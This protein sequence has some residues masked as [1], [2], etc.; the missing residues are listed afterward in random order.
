MKAT[1]LRTRL[2]LGRAGV[3][4]GRHAGRRRAST[5]LA[6]GSA[7]IGAVLLTVMAVLAVF[8]P[9]LAP[10]DPSLPVAAPY[11]PPSAAHWLGTNDIGQDLLS[12]LLVGARVSLAIGL[13]AAAVS[14]AFGTL[15]GILAGALGGWVDGVLMRLTDVVLTLPFL[16]LVIVLATFFGPSL[17]TTA[18][19]LSLVIWARPARVVRSQA[20]T[21]EGRA[22]VEAAHALGGR[23]THV[24]RRHIL[25]AV[26]PVALSQFVLA[27]S[28]AVLAEASLAF[29]GLGDPLS[30]SWGSILFY[31]QTRGAFLTGAWPWWVLP[32]GLMIAATVL[33][34]ALLGRALERA[35]TPQAGDAVGRARR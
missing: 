31:A 29:L 33:G 20:L 4:S 7:R 15:V 16:P 34:F 9:A 10:Y 19:V 22:Y 13:L 18:A 12:E 28:S 6:S 24:L 17:V 2:A 30:K 26:A 8:G 23:A 21:V 35:L 5:A 14:V 3:P 27:V 11:Q 32:P 25:P 1:Q